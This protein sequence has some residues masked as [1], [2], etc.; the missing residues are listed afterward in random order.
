MYAGE[1][2]YRKHQDLLIN[3]AGKLKEKIPNLK[4]LLAGNGDLEVQYRKQI[5]DLDVHTQVELLGF[6]KDIDNLMSLAD[7]AVSASRQ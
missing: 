7:L 5:E 1:L 2:S 6:R 4:V 3:V